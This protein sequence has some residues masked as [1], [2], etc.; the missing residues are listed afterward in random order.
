MRNIGK[1][2]DL[3][4]E[5]VQPRRVLWDQN[6]PCLNLRRLGAHARH[7]VFFGLYSDWTQITFVAKVLNQA[8]TTEQSGDLK[9][10][11]KR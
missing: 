3:G 7:L 2:H 5:V 4:F 10:G 11:T 9:G 8:R 6:A 1:G